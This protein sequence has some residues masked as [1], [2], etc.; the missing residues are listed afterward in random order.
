MLGHTC[1]GFQGTGALF[2]QSWLCLPLHGCMPGRRQASGWRPTFP[3]G[4]GWTSYIACDGPELFALQQQ[5]IV[6]CAHTPCMHLPSTSRVAARCHG[7]SFLLTG[8]HFRL[9]PAAGHLQRQWPC[10][11][12]SVSSLRRPLLPGIP[13]GRSLPLLPLGTGQ[14][15]Q[16]SH[17][18]SN[19]Q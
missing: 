9:C 10:Q 18:D 12:F 5:P 17:A 8:L 15:A 7:S 16:E 2:Y 14:H 3:V 1:T 13:D 6:G 19:H 11:P 4:T